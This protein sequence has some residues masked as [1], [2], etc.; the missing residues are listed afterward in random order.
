MAYDKTTGKLINNVVVTR[1]ATQK[2]VKHKTRPGASENPKGRS[3]A[4]GGL[5][6]NKH[7]KI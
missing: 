6:G 7:R 1:K 4:T 2:P 5:K 3:T